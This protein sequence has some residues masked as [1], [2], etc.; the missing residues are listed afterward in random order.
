MKKLLT[1]VTALTLVFAVA[2]CKDDTPSGPSD[3][4]NVAAAK[5]AL[6]LTD[7]NEVT[8]DL[9][10]P[11]GGLNDSVITWSSSN[12]AVLSD[13][14]VV[15]RPAVGTDNVVVT[16]TATITIGDA[17][18]TKD[19][20]VRVIAAVPSLDV[21]I[22][23]L[24]AA[25]VEVGD[26][27]VVTGTVFGIVVG[28]GV[29]ISDGTG[30]IYVYNNGAVDA[31]I[32]DSIVV[33][34]EKGI[35]YGM[36]QVTEVSSIVVA[37]SG[38]TVPAYAV[39]SIVDLL[40][41]DPD[42]SLLHSK[43]ITITGVVEVRNIDGNDTTF[44]I[45]NDAA[46]NNFKVAI[47]YKSD[48]AKVTEISALAGKMVTAEVVA[49]GYHDGLKAWRATVNA[50]A[51][52]TSTVLTDAEK[53][54]YEV[55][56]VDLG[57]SLDEVTADLVL[58]TSGLL[59]G[60]TI[61]W[62]SSA[63]AVVTDMG[64]VTRA[65]ADGMATLTASVTIGSATETKDFA[66]TVKDMNFAVEGITVAAALALA[67]DAEFVLE[68]TV[69]AI[70]SGDFVLQDAD[71][72]GIIVHSSSFIE[73]NSLAL[74]DTILVRGTRDTYNDL[75]QIAD[76]E[77]I[78]T[79]STGN[80][81]FITPAVTVAMIVGDIVT[82]QGNNVVLTGLTIVEMDDGYGY[83]TVKDAAANEIIFP[84]YQIPYAE[85]LWA[86]DDVI[87]LTVTVWGIHYGNPRVFVYDYPELTDAEALTY[88]AT[89]VVLDP[90]AT[91]DLDLFMDDLFGVTVVWTTDTAAVITAA[92]VVT[93]PAM[94]QPNVDVVMTATL[95]I[96]T[97]TDV[98]VNNTVT[99][100]APLDPTE[101]RL[102]ISEYIEGGGYNKAIE[103]YNP[104]DA[105]I[106]LANY[107][108]R[109]YSA[110]GTNYSEFNLV[111][112][113][114]AGGTFVLV[115]NNAAT[116][117]ILK[118]ASDIIDGFINHNGD[119]TYELLLNGVVMDS[120]GTWGDV[121]WGK[122]STFVRIATNINGSVTFNAAQWTVLAKDTMTEIG[123][124]TYTPAP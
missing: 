33:T 2:G 61:V 72:T 46:N 38:N 27:V 81:V 87:E 48:S 103:L 105:T 64:V 98:V 37:S 42:T 120:L 100:L 40:A 60:T 62:T 36:P 76:A 86:V 35:Y 113:I 71:G 67:D 99:V 92:G 58:N 3:A 49:Y 57:A 16:L 45:A 54:A 107:T 24:L 94:G 50:D 56:L 22:A 89:Q 102:F 39:T 73:T 5:T 111:G 13:A 20:T 112:T 51:V 23:E 84:T 4:D 78:S 115:N 69:S 1:L 119:D 121:D 19:F 85:T 65:A 79:V 53:A 80:T 66:I 26:V 41:E 74:G 43:P 7:L 82:Y 122:D 118:D 59:A 68:A 83:M 44:F 21:T 75:N 106:D 114:A 9:T 8:A 34:G 95:S 97:E 47:Y 108:L 70:F 12:T 18:E 17:S 91:A 14:G 11:A 88:I 104:T 10:L 63:P 31:V 6:L 55:S 32:G 15:T 52:V 96:G 28:A 116:D 90:A 117:Q 77:Y 25:T 109:Y 101:A 110:G 124:H 30:F 123:A 29:Q 93:I